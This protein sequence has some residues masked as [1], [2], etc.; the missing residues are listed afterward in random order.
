MCLFV[1]AL[2]PSGVLFVRCLALPSMNAPPCHPQDE[3]VERYLHGVF[4]THCHKTDATATA[5]AAARDDG[6]AR[7]GFINAMQFSSIWRQVPCIPY[8][9]YIPCIPYIP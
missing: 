3:A 4:E 5:T 7:V 6:T 8:I 2:H 9:P 1:T